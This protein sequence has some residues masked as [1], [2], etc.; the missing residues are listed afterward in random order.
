MG[1]IRDSAANGRRVTETVFDQGTASSR[2]GAKV[3]VQV[4]GGRCFPAEPGQ[5]RKAANQQRNETQTGDGDSQP[6]FAIDDWKTSAASH[7][8]HART[9]SR[10]T[11]YGQTT[12]VTTAAR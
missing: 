4:A 5:R 6:Q 10:Q 12:V 8:Q 3:I 7:E 1:R 2:R 9:A 11:G